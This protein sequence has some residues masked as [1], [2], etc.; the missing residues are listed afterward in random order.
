MNATLRV[1]QALEGALDTNGGTQ[2]EIGFTPND[3]QQFKQI[4]NGQ[5]QCVMRL[6]MRRGYFHGHSLL[7]VQLIDSTNVL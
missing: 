7:W 6:A 4:L 1:A 2:G 3:F 5:K